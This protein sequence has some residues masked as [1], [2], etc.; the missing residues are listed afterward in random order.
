MSTAAE[1][2]FITDQLWKRLK[3]LIPP[4]APAINGH[5]GQPRVPNR[6]TF[7]GIVFVLL[8]GIPWKKLPVELGYGSGI[9]CWRR[10]REWSEAG[11][12]DVG[13]ATQDRAR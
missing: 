12:W 5:T 10:L 6:K 2:R 11:V 13:A 9:T 8:T 4:P 1:D 7:A 3:L